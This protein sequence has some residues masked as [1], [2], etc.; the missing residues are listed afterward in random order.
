[1]NHFYIKRKRRELFKQILKN[2]SNKEIYQ[3]YSKS[4]DLI[5]KCELDWSICIKNKNFKNQNLN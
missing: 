4:E 3:N 2:I 5:T 1:M